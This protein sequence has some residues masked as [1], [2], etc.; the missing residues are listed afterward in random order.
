VIKW[1]SAFVDVPPERF[2]ETLSFWSAATAATAS[3]P[4][5]DTDQFVTL[6]PPSG[7]SHLRMQRHTGGPAR[8]H[9]DFHVESIAEAAEHALNLGATQVDDRGYRIMRSPGGYTFCLVDHHGENDRGPRLTTPA[10]HRL[11]VVCVDAPADLFDDEVRFWSEFCGREVSTHD[12]FP[13]FAGLGLRHDGLPWNLLVQH[14]GSG[15]GRHDAHAHLDISAGKHVDV[16]MERHIEL[17]ATLDERYADW[18]IMRDP[19]S[20]AYCITGRDPD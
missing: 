6:E 13:E 15:D 16:V 12:D 9:L 4:R 17:G 3:A 7:D 10:E 2:E 8:V 1:I 19:A 18:V 5:G 14:L 20:L 11:D